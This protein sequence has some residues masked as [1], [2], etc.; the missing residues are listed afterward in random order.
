MVTGALLTGVLVYAPPARRAV[1]Q[2]AGFVLVASLVLAVVS[3][4][5]SDVKRM[6]TLPPASSA[7]ALDLGSEVP[8]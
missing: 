2:V 7:S 3:V 1:Y 6:F 5:T 8:R 4:R